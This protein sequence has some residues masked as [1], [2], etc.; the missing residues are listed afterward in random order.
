M[1]V[2]RGYDRLYNNRRMFP[3]NALDNF[4][5]PASNWGVQAAGQATTTVATV[6]DQAIVPLAILGFVSL[7][8]GAV[9]AW[10][11]VRAKGWGGR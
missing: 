11:F 10:R 3:R 7:V 4:N 5:A 9:V 2:P 1:H 8:G 6:A